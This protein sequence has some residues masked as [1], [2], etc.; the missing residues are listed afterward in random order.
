MKKQ[1]LL[2]MVISI[3]SGT[4]TSIVMSQ[5]MLVSADAKNSRKILEANIFL[6]RDEKD[7]IRGGFFMKNDRPYFALLDENQKPKLMLSLEKSGQPAI[8]LSDQNY[9]DRILLALNEKG[10]PYFTAR[11]P[12]ERPAIEL[13]TPKN[14]GCIRLR[15]PH[16]KL[17]IS[18]WASKTEAVAGAF[19]EKGR[20]RSTMYYK[21]N[22]G[23]GF[24]SKDKNN[25]NRLSTIVSDSESNNTIM[26]THQKRKEFLLAGVSEQGSF[27]RLGSSDQ[28]EST[29]GTLGFK[30]TVPWLWL[31]NN[32]GAS[33]R[34]LIYPEGGPYLDL[35]IKKRRIWSAPD[36]PPAGFP[37]KPK[38]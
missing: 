6:L 5:L 24:V 4:L 13:A 28:A 8:I 26:I 2:M 30:D 36:P 34:G 29:G 25:I 18:L 22:V 10:E 9:Q 12:D 19:D 33:I 38:K 21:T 17:G 37:L 15:S 35:A 27:V 31:Q 23:T 16:D 7:K 20:M 14:T 3:I 1:V 32:Q 11:Y